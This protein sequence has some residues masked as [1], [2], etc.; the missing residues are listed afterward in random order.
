MA[1]ATMVAYG[2]MIGVMIALAVITFALRGKGHKVAEAT[3]T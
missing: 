1:E 3:G 2:S